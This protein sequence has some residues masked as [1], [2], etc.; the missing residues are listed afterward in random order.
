[1]NRRHLLALA[2]ASAVT[3]FALPAVAEE[4]V[5]VA[6]VYV[7]PVGDAGW[8]YA[9]DQ[10][11]VALE[12]AMG[13][14]VKTSYVESVPEGADAE[15]VIRKLALN[16]NNVIFTTSFGYMNP[17]AKVAKAFPHIV[18]EHATGFTVDKNVG[19]YETRLYEG[20]YLNG[21]LAGKMSKSNLLGVVASFPIP[22]VIRNIDAFTLGAQSVNP[23]I[24]TKVIWVNT[25]YDP[26]KERQAAETLISEGVD[27]I[28]QNTD[29][30]ATLQ[31]A[32]E[33]GVYA[34][35]WNS[36]M[37]KFA[38]KAQLTAATNDWSGY[39]IETVKAVMAGTWKSTQIHGGLKEGMIKMAALNPVIPADVVKI[40]E[41]KKKALTAGTL[42][43]FQGPI[44]DQ[45]GAIKV[46][47]GTELP[48][49]KLLSMDFY[50]QGVEG[51]IPK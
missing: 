14:K 31:V 35:G 15:R 38:P 45:S 30:P 9:H 8:T 17:T 32:Q 28:N 25:W 36:D 13:G 39:Y 33:K 40:Y 50:V 21:V 4:P 51:V 48:L 3:S 47:A 44:K 29:S 22:E 16:G 19:T 20:A 2:V 18:F 46:A 41:E 27:V 6:F 49:P 23:A 7:G 12:K 1:M 10:A 26:A 24:K 11:R 34:F 37:A 42:V 43:P 5:K